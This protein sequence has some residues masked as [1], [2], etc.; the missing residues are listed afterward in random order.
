MSENKKAHDEVRINPSI[1]S[2]RLAIEAGKGQ[3][4]AAEKIIASAALFDLYLRGQIRFAIDDRNSRLENFDYSIPARIKI[5]I[6][7]IDDHP[8]SAI[9]ALLRFGNGPGNVPDQVLSG[10]STLFGRSSHDSTPMVDEQHPAD[11]YSAG[12]TG[13]VLG[14]ACDQSGCV[15]HD[16]PAEQEERHDCGSFPSPTD[17]ELRQHGCPALVEP[18]ARTFLC[19]LPDSD[20]AAINAGV[21]PTP[22]MKMMGRVAYDELERRGEAENA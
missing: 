22:L 9:C 8:A 1:E 14:H 12:R 10:H 17:A 4:W 18:R 6:V 15:V 7:R 19:Q 21:I 2:L 16:G 20:L 11:S 5:S 13:S 3:T